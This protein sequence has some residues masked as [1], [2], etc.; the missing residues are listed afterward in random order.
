MQAHQGL[1]KQLSVGREA[2]K[3]PGVSAS[4]S[5]HSDDDEDDTVAEVDPSGRYS[6]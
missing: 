1:S 5:R 2:T 4:L 6:R 3:D